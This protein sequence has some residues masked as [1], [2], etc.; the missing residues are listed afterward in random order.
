MPGPSSYNPQ[1]PK[2]RKGFFASK[3]RAGNAFIDDATVRGME[4]PGLQKV[5]YVNVLSIFRN[6][7]KNMCSTIK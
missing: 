5:N 7:L 3:E 2:S 4:T 1:P 6:L